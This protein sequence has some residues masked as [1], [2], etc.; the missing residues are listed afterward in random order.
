[1]WLV[2]NRGEL[3]CL[4]TEGFR[5]G[6]NDGPYQRELVESGDEA[7]VVW[8]LDMMGELGVQQHNM[9]NCSVTGWNGCLFVCTSNG[10]DKSHENIPAPHAPSFLAVDAA[11]GA[12]LWADNSPGANILHGQWSSPAFAVLGRVPQVVFAGG[13]GWLYSFHARGDRSDGAHLLWKF[14]CNPKQSIWQKNGAGTRNNIIATPVIH[15]GLVY[16]ATG[17]D[18][19]QRVGRA[20]LWCIDPTHRMDGSDVS[21]ELAVDGDGNPL[22]HRRVQAVDPDS[23]ERAA[24][25]PDSALVWHYNGSDQ[26]GD[27]AI[28]FAEC[29]H[30]TLC[31]VAIRDGLL[32]LPDLAGVVHCLDARTGTVHWT[33]DLLDQ[34]WASPLIV[35]GKV[36]VASASGRVAVFRLHADPAL[37]MHHGEAI[38]PAEMG[39]P[40]HATPIVADNVLYIA[41]SRRLFAIGTRTESVVRE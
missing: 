3:V 39:A 34:V 32:I 38:A 41:T 30:R 10:V 31:S 26:D 11:T 7:D 19:Q 28:D 23:G 15:D 21:A 12:I 5:D 16:V 14:D 36:Y 1:M 25:N 27:G 2:S 13:D 37:A 18:P 20:D 22:P 17:L 6:E 29:L 40:I 9:A 33:C 35:D 8:V 4:D 24:R